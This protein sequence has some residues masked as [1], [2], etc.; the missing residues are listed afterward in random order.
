[1]KSTRSKFSTLKQV[2]S[3]DEYLRG[4]GNEASHMRRH[5]G[6]AWLDLPLSVPQ[7]PGA[8]A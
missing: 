1:M 5:T 3:A 8:G 7:N 4:T 2:F 6:L